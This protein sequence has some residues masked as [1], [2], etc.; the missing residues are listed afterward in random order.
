MAI[1]LPHGVVQD[2]HVLG[3]YDP[4]LNE[5][6]EQISDTE[7]LVQRNLEIRLKTKLD[8]FHFVGLKR[9]S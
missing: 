8:L 3:C 9:H 6:P 1:D 5:Q 2:P 7:N 4:S